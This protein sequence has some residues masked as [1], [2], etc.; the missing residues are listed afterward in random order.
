M[1]DCEPVKD[2]SRTELERQLDDIER[3]IDELQAEDAAEAYIADKLASIEPELPKLS[4]SMAFQA[5]RICQRMRA[6]PDTVVAGEIA[7]L[8]ARKVEIEQA[9][10]PTDEV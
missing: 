7:R 4:A 5:E 2:D 6:E 8:E 10:E 3:R 1:S 9:L